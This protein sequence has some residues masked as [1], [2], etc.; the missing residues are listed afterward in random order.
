MVLFAKNSSKIENFCSIS[1]LCLSS[2][3]LEKLRMKR[4]EDIQMLENVHL[5]GCAQHG[6]KKL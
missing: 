3:V 2:K 5:M 6:F 4:I 1:N